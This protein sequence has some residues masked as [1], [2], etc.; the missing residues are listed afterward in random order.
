M[1]FINES[2][3]K[4]CDLCIDFC[5]KKVLEKQH[6]KAIIANEEACIKCGICERICPD[7]AIS[8]RSD[9]NE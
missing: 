7:F 3:C 5:P 4:G 8:L 6:G 2:Y 9:K 1:L